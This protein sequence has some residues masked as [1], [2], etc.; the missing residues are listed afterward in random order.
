MSD[1]AH[2]RTDGVP[3]GV[4]A[5]AGAL[6]A[7]ALVI[8]MFSRE[9]DIGV[10]HMPSVRAYQVLHLRFEDG[11]DGRV[12]IRDA[13]DGAELFTVA[14]GTGGFL[15]SAVRGFAH[16]RNRDGV[17]ASPPFTLTRWSDGTISLA[18]EA[19]GRRIDLDAFGP[20]QAQAFARLFNARETAK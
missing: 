7:F 17:D 13:A 8:T 19:T 15:R 11:D 12:T 10:S 20:T 18:D 3:R 5:A 4:L 16:V 14:P 9:S 6:V 2:V 1:T